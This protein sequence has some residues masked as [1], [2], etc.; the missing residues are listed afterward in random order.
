L[1][2][3]ILKGGLLLDIFDQPE[4][5]RR[6]RFSLARRAFHLLDPRSNDG[7]LTWNVLD[8]APKDAKAHPTLR[9]APGFVSATPER[10]ASAERDFTANFSLSYSAF[11]FG[12]ARL[13][14]VLEPVSLGL[15]E[16]Q[17]AANLLGVINQTDLFGILWR[18]PEVRSGQRS[19]AR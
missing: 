12:M 16:V 1:I 11:E 5:A 19:A 9:A 18:A 15:C 10:E 6:Y 3:L 13:S 14:L 17:Q 7:L 8:E 2:L 4:S